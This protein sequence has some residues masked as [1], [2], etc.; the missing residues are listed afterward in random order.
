MTVHYLP[1]AEQRRD[2]R[3]YELMAMPD[4][5][6][7]AVLRDPSRLRVSALRAPSL[8]QVSNQGTGAAQEA[9]RRNHGN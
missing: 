1:S 8:S 2:A 7:L 4:G 9:A 3:L 6:R 5:P